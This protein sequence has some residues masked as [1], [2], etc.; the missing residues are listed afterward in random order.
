MLHTLGWCMNQ[1]A[2]SIWGTVCLVDR[3][4]DSRTHRRWKDT[5][6]NRRKGKKHRKPI[7]LG[8]SYNH[9]SAS[10]LS[11]SLFLLLHRRRQPTPFCC[12][13]S[14]AVSCR[15][16]EPGWLRTRLWEW[17]VKEEGKERWVWRNP[18]HKEKWCG[19]FLFEESWWW[20]MVYIYTRIYLYILYIHR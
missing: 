18:S 11:T 19:L 9:S 20:I 3:I 1:V 8:T 2:K 5:W 17:E 12:G 15:K 13:G 7:S 10:S 4:W 6:T 14:H 16:P